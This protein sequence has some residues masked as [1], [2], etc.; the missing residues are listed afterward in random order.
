MDEDPPLEDLHAVDEGSW[1]ESIAAQAPE[2]D[3]GLP[4]IRGVVRCGGDGRH[5]L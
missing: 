5:E 1:R 3:I 2:V 4:A